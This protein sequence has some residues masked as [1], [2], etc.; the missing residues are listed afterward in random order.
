MNIYD[1]V[2]RA[3]FVACALLSLFLGNASAASFDCAEQMDKAQGAKILPLVES[4]YRSVKDLT[5]EFLQQSLFAGLERRETSKG[6]LYFAKPGMMDWV[7]EQ[8]EAQRFVTDGKT[9]WYYQ[10]GFNQVTVTDFSTS[11]S[12]QVPVTFLLGVG[13]LSDSF[14]LASACKTGEG[15]L[16]ELH[17]KRTDDNLSKF[18]LLVRASDY[19]PSG[20][21]V[22]DVGG[23]ETQIL[24]LGVEINKGTAGRRFTFDIPRGADVI[25]Q[26]SLPQAERSSS[27]SEA[28]IVESPSK[29]AD[30]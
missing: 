17:P 19:A 12:S 5:S 18:Y 13:S 10:P 14:E 11:F 29:G 20:A 9:V 22:L 2:A 25:D 24:L 1:L 8:P 16:L 26:R 6:H 3:A 7:Y 30:H 28:T 27:I 4:K 15:I 23:N 21:R